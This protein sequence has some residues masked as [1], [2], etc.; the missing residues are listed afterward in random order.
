M[1]YN[2]FA[3]EKIHPLTVLLRVCFS[4]LKGSKLD[5]AASDLFQM[6]RDELTKQGFEIKY[7]PH[8]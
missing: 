6:R 2:H 4:V 7:N 1:K 5:V 8:E 3:L